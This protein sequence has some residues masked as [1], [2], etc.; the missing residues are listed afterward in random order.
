LC[1]AAFLSRGAVRFHRVV[2]D[3]PDNGIGF[4]ALMF[5][6]VCVAQCGLIIV[7]WVLSSGAGVR[8]FVAAL[9]A[10]PAV[11]IGYI[12]R[13]VIEAFSRGRPLSI[14]VSVLSGLGVTVSGAAHAGLVRGCRRPPS[15]ESTDDADSRRAGP[16]RE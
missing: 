4:G 16:A 11:F 10:P 13:D 12:A 5:V 14:E 8:A 3:D 1:W 7:P 6:F 9:M 2:E 15:A